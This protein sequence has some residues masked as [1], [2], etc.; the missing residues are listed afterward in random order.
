[1]SNTS[2]TI[3]DY[4][5]FNTL[6]FDKLDSSSFSSVYLN[7][8]DVDNSSSEIDENQSELCKKDFY[9]YGFYIVGIKPMFFINTSLSFL[10]V[11]LNSILIYILIRKP[12]ISAVDVLLAALGLTDEFTSQCM[13]FPTFLGHL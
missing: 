9:A 7:F 6:S 8:S 3:D 2:T 10:V 13:C 4:F 1:M 12:N 5:S 11:T